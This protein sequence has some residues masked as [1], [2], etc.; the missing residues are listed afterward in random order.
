VTS[1]FRSAHTAN[2]LKE[3][4]TETVS[5]IHFGHNAFHCI[6]CRTADM[7]PLNGQMKISS[8][9]G[10]GRKKIGHYTNQ[11]ILHEQHKTP[12]RKER[13]QNNTDKI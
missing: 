7:Y 5:I 4:D 6:F 12:C 2:G 10:D 13:V 3:D 11:L 9:R 8:L 1:W